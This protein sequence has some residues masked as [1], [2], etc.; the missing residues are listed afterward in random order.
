MRLAHALRGPSRRALMTAS[1]AAIV[2]AKR[3][4]GSVLALQYVR[5][6]SVNRRASSDGVRTKAAARRATSTTSIPIT[7]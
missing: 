4:V 7:G 6:A 1:L 2:P 5:S 3:V